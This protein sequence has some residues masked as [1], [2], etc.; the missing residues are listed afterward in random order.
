MDMTIRTALLL[1]FLASAPLLAAGRP[2]I[3]VILTDDSGYTDLGCYGGE[4]DTP[5]IDKLA[6][7]GLRFRTFYTNAR[8]S[9]TRASLMT[10]RDSAYAGFAA[11]TLGGGRREMKLPPYRARMPYNLPTIAELL[12]AAGYRTMMAGKWH[13]GGSLAKNSPASQKAWERIHAGWELTPDEMDA[14]FNALPAQRGFDE[15]FGLI[16]GETEHFFTPSDRHQYLE[17]NAPA[18]L[19]YDRVYTMC[20]IPKSANKEHSNNG[21]TS[22]AFYDADGITDRAIGMIKNAAT[23]KDTPF[24][25]YL[26]YRAPHAPMEAPQSLVDKYLPRYADLGKVEGNRVAGLIRENLFP[27]GAP[28]RAAFQQKPGAP[29]KESSK[30]SPLKLAV[31]AAM[32]ETV[33]INVGRLMETLDETG[34]LGNTLVFYLSDNG[35]APGSGE[36]LNKPYAGAKALLWE[37]GAKTHCIASWPGV[38]KPGTITDTIGWVGDFLPTCLAVAGGTYPAEFR[39][40]RTAPPDGRNLLP[41]LK[42]EEMPPPEYLFFNDRGQQGVVC[43]GRWKLL[44]EPGWY[45]QTSKA[46]GIAY[47]LY[48][49]VNDPAETENL[50]GQFPEL[51][52]KLAA[53]CAAWQQRC[54]IVDYAEILTLNPNSGN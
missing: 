52:Q 44:I 39:G 50:A 11:G 43:K 18:T 35:A 27:G 32:L 2:N 12:K 37:G 36:L 25:I 24:F 22:P 15:F 5:N 26:A 33:D 10:G 49:L 30:I 41:A 23:D 1:L 21:K 51:V 29:A 6:R 17:G 42:G 3:V 45:Q 4:I 46:E 47:E 40:A 53:E 19:P 7:N 54:G 8:C 14:D 48:D 38:I 28:Y 9:P 13:L 16:E 20:C 34:R 31:H